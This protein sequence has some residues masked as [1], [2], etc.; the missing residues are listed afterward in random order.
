MSDNKEK[1]QDALGMLDDDLLLEVEKLRRA[2]QK[3]RAPM[4][5][6]L[7]A[8]A[9]CLCMMVGAVYAA[10]FMGGRSGNE[11]F[12]MADGAGTVAE[13]AETEEGML[14]EDAVESE[15]AMAEETAM[16]EDAEECYETSE[17][18]IRQNVA[19]GVLPA[20]TGVFV[21]PL[22]VDLCDHSD[23]IVDMIPF[24]IYQGRSYV[25]Y[26]TLE[27]ASQLIGGYLGTATG[28]IDEW[29]EEDGYVELAGSVMGDFY[30]VNGFETDFVL[31]M[32]RSDGP[33][34]IFMNNNDITLYTG[35]DL[36]QE[37]F[38]VDGQFTAK[39][40]SRDRW[41]NSKGVAYEMDEEGSEQ[42]WALVEAMFDAPFVYTDDITLRGDADSI[43]DAELYHLY[44]HLDNGMVVHL[45]LFDGGYVQLDGLYPV[46]IQ[47]EEEV[48]WQAVKAMDQTEDS[49]CGVPLMEDE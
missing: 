34:E 6:R 24:F 15:E 40:M 4:W 37:R 12:L 43:Y 45:R 18:E 27:D 38:K 29:T 48:F 2:P 7:A 32:Q 49:L 14:T 11:E 26:G 22:M 42:I 44:L 41:F 10:R 20:A 21:E 33:V 19:G 9:A 39:C 47:V 35:A 1:L 46:C 30:G 23:R 28:L 5:H 31:C 16:E 3:R 17:G 8:I 36:L 13:G 25:Y